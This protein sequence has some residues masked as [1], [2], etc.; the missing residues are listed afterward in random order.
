MCHNFYQ[1]TG[2][3]DLSFEDEAS[4]LTSHGHEVLRFTRHN[5][6]V[7]N[8]GA[9]NVAARA[10]WNEDA[11]RAMRELIRSKRPGIVHITNTFPLLSPSVCYAAKHEGVPT[12]M[13]LR[14]Y[15]FF[16]LNGYFLRG[17]RVCE[18]CLGK[19][20]AWPGVLHGCYRNNRPAS[21]V[22]A[23]V[24]NR[25]RK[26]WSGDQVIDQYF[27]LTEFARKKFIQGGFEAERIQVKGGCVIPDS[28][29]A[30]GGG[31][32]AIFV[33]RLSPEKGVGT[34]L[35]AW[36]QLARPLPLKI[37]GDGPL[38]GTVRRAAQTNPAVEY[39]GYRP[40]E[41]VLSR[42]GEATC[43]IMPSLW[44]ETFGRTVVESYSRGTPV[45]ASRIGSLVE[46]IAEGRTGL[47]FEPGNAQ[48]L[49][50]A[51]RQLLD[52]GD[53]SP[54]RRQARREFETKFTAEMNYALL[55]SIY[56][57]ARE[58][59]SATQQAC[60]DTGHGPGS[61]PEFD[62]SPRNGS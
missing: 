44:Y 35:S 10:V 50:R 51:V 12:V 22:T 5:E 61:K 42:I 55:M 7:K 18:D 36:S 21:A 37:I 14:N 23:A 13:A 16:C 4:L 54:W 53:L 33:G 3:E 31:G 15:R 25:Y 27:T 56:G 62:A 26:M 52:Q 24:L 30:P 47:L 6:E 20:L 59:A 41:E 57:K 40:P 8:L 58:R 46:L 45:I 60:P 17:G 38:A 28:G 11:Y 34:L 19:R 2:G 48:D 1:Q 9:W 29:L 49:A 32:F 43:L 39:L